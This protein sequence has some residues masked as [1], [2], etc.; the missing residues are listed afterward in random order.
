MPVAF[1]KSFAPGEKDFDFVLQQISYAPERDD[2]VDF[3]DS[4]YDVNQALVTSGGSRR[5]GGNH[6]RGAEGREAR[7]PDRDHEPRP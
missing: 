1:N 5:R 4:Y 7:R 6:D 3:S 2:A